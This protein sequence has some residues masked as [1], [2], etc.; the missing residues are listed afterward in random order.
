MCVS[1]DDKEDPGHRRRHSFNVT[2]RQ[3]ELWKF[4]LM[5]YGSSKTMVADLLVEVEFVHPSVRAYVFPVDPRAEVFRTE[6]N[7]ELPT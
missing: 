7:F 5:C 4:G 1:G 6:E 3:S 2:F